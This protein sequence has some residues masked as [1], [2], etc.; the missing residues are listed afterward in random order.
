VK[1]GLEWQAGRRWRGGSG[2]LATLRAASDPAA[3]GGEYYGPP[4]R[5]QFTG[6]PVRVESSARS[7][8]EADAGRLWAI[9]EKLTGV[10]YGALAASG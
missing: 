7:H 6:Y 5:L 9:S 2:A 1:G 4:G 8:D 10:S 3:R